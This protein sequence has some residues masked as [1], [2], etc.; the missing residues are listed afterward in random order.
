MK[1]RVL[2]LISLLLAGTTVF[3]TACQHGTDEPTNGETTSDSSVFDM[4]DSG[5]TDG[6]TDG[7]DSSGNQTESFYFPEYE[8]DPAPTEKIT[9]SPKR[10]A[11]GKSS[12]FRVALDE[13]GKLFCWGA[14]DYGQVGNGEETTISYDATAYTPQEAQTDARF[15]SVSAGAKHALAID[16]EGN[17]WGWGQFDKPEGE[18]SEGI[19][20]YNIPTQLMKGKKYVYAEAGSDCSFIIDEKGKLWAWGDSGAFESEKAVHFATDK[21]FSSVS[22]YN[23]VAYAIDTNGTL[24]GWGKL[25]HAGIG[26]GTT[27][28]KLTPTA[29]MPKKKF[30]QVTTNGSQAYAID[31]NG[32]LWGWGA[33]AKGRLGDGTQEKQ[34]AP[35][36]IMQGKYFTYVETTSSD[37]E[38]YAIDV[39]GDLWAW[40]TESAVLNM[41]YYPQKVESS[42]KFLQVSK[43]LALDENGEFWSWGRRTNG[44][45]GDGL[46]Q[47]ILTPTKVFSNICFA[48]ISSWIAGTYAIDI[49]GKLWYWGDNNR[50]TD[51]SLIQLLSDKRFKEISMGEYLGGKLFAIDN[52]DKLWEIS[53]FGEVEATQIMPDKKFIAVKSGEEFYFAIDVNYNLWSW[54]SCGDEGGCLGLGTGVL[55]QDTPAMV[56]PGTKFVQVETGI[57]Y[58]A[59]IDIYG[60]FWGWGNNKPGPLSTKENRA[61]YWSPVQFRK[62]QRFSFLA[63]QGVS[64]TGVEAGNYAL[65]SEGK[66]Y[67]W[68]GYKEIVNI[69]TASELRLEHKTFTAVATGGRHTLALD[70]EGYIW[71]WGYNSHGQLG[72]GFKGMKTNILGA[73]EVMP[74]K[75]FTFIEATWY[76]SFAIDTE[77]KLWVWG[78]NAHGKLNGLQS[79]I[80]LKKLNLR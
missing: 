40:G 21:T 65:D 12:S 46:T 2:S 18:S 4:T 79:Q 7:S 27:G 57:D 44:G 73:Q 55:Q 14:N 34:L 49:E 51:N 39:Q 6:S 47:N 11:S 19:H 80:Q 25:S 35:V 29:I 53:N 63:F 72:T 77:G 61:V 69:N 24:W 58:V 26:D 41:K 48:K 31:E 5:S 66:L 28:N 1:K 36:P 38:T 71:T 68:H 50:N 32:N 43:G 16:E 9:V 22:S 15:V 20:I 30:V 23:Q 45:V 52:E 3:L 54:G 59:A 67:A 17:L 10:I 76:S 78:D 42:V 60:N 62:E 33:N 8:P 37:A 56:A 74:E 75:K 64:N 13:E 70:S